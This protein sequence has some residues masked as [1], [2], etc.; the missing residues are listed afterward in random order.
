[1]YGCDMDNIA[2]LIRD[3][4][5]IGQ[6]VF[7]SFITCIIGIFSVMLFNMVERFLN[8]TLPVIVRGWPPGYSEEEKDEDTEKKDDDE[9]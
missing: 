9:R 1:M 6:F 8:H 2:A 3:W 4:H 7:L 5:P